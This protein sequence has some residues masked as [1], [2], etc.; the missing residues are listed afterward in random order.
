MLPVEY[1]AIG[2]KSAAGVITKATLT[3]AYAGNAKIL[4]SHG[5][6]DLHLDVVYTPQAAQT[7]RY[8]EIIIE[9][10]DEFDNVVGSKS[11]EIASPSE[12]DVF[13]NKENRLQ[14]IIPGEKSELAGKTLTADWDC[15]I[16]NYK[17]KIS[18]RENAVAGTPAS[19]FG[20]IFIN[21]RMYVSGKIG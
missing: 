6:T 7:D 8:A 15:N 9:S 10:L 12:R 21:A 19:N 2:S 4:F 5:F 20:A 1:S 3:N 16:M 13:S 17:T 18:V 14:I 11:V